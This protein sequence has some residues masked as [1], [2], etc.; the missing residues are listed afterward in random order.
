MDFGKK[1]IVAL[2]CLTL[3]F[4]AFVMSGC[5][6]ETKAYY[7]VSYNLN[8]KGGDTREYSVRS[9][10]SAPDWK[11]TRDG[12]YLNGWYTDASCGKSYDFSK[13]VQSDL[14]LYA[15]WR[16]K[17]GIAAVTFDFDCFGAKNRTIEV[18][19]Q[20]LIAA[21]Y[22]P[23]H[24]RL[25]MNFTGWYTDE[26]RTNAW[27]F[28]TDTVTDSMT[29]YAG[30]EIDPSFVER[31]ED[32]NVKYEQVSVTVWNP[33][34]SFISNSKLEKLAE[35]FSL[36][37]EGITINVT[38]SL[39]SQEATMLRLQQTPG[40]LS[41][42]ENYYSV[43]DVFDVAGIPF[44]VADF[45]EGASRECIMDEV[46]VQLP[47]VGIAPYIV[48]N[49]TLMEKYNGGKELPYSYSELSTLLRAA[50]AGESAGNAQFKSIVTNSQWPFREAPSYTAFAQNGAPYYRYNPERGKYN[51]WKEPDVLQKAITAMTNTYNLFSENG[52]NHGSYSYND[53]GPA[54]SAVA[55]GKALMALVN[56]R[57]Q[58][59]KILGNSNLGV[60]S[61]SGLFT[62]NTDAEAASI[63][64]HTVGFA[65]Y[66]KAT[67]VNATQMCA[68]ALFADYVAKHAY[69]FAED[70][71][72]PL[73]KS[74]YAEMPEG[75]NVIKLIRSVV[76]PEN[77]VTLDGAF[78]LKS[79]V[80]STVAENFIL[81]ILA[82]DG[83]DI[84]ERMVDL[85]V[86]IS[87]QL[88]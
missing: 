58:E 3:T 30:Y 21:K 55:D 26:A 70:A 52:A 64:V 50:Y 74:A 19:K 24:N 28:G 25:G 2:L 81:Q 13:K 6:K 22:V 88:Y 44:D 17:P 29:L 82:G 73:R 66:K 77:L 76:N 14:T 16:E 1:S 23:E 86:Q 46:M 87:G 43:A 38:S 40:F 47:L 39:T 32:G 37:H 20:S 12:Y 72:I 34:G 62:D 8:Y 65:F 54:V 53:D 18:E 69:V 63:P 4:G 59:S 10:T 36:E 15:G 84:A 45:Y 79:I 5:G 67:S 56:F 83:S 60:M 35:E 71:V 51:D 49:K 42:S 75:N 11:A 57:G 85:G 9:G 80:N 61:L 31:D 27:D 48:Y 33:S 41:T 68:A 78:T 7:T